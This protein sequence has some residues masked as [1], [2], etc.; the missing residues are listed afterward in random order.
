MRLANVYGQTET[1]GIITRTAEGAS[2]AVMAETI[3]E[4]LPGAEL[5]IADGA[6]GAAVPAGE[7]GEIQVRGPYIMSG[8]F[9]N[10]EATSAAFTADGFLHTGD[11]GVMRA[12]GNVVFTGRLKEMFKSGGY[13]VY[14]VEVEQAICEH[15]AAALAAVVAT[16]HATFQEVGCAFIELTPGA[17]ASA[18]ELRDFLR[19]RIANYKIP[20]RFVIEAALPKL[21]NGKLDKLALKARTLG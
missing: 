3:G 10:P 17:A 12:D 8:Y 11:L 2:L 18:D 16:P 15:P 1:C 4:V 19:A 13:N 9:R 14:P 21:P 6:T 5:R 7:P 20:K